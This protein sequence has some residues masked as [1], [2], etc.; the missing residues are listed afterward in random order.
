MRITIDIP[1]DIEEML[2]KKC[3]E[4]GLS[5]SEFLNALIEWYFLKKKKKTSPESQEFVNT[6][7]KIANERKL[8]CK[9]SDGSHCA[10]EVLDDIFEEKK[11]EPISPY[12]CL[13]CLDFHD[14]RKLPRKGIEVE[15][16][17]NIRLN[18]HEIAKLAARYLYELYGDKLGYQPRMVI[19]E[20]EESDEKSITGKDLRKLLKNW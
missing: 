9:Y 12:K 17:E 13:F 14:R 6:A 1:P 15:G 19:E 5:P 8:Y 3:D 20:I 11:P 2:Y 4:A 18:V 16:A 7:I 10:L